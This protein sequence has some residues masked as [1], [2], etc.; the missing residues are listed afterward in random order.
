MRKE[1][2]WG[3]GIE[4]VKALY[5]LKEACIL[6]FIDSYKT[7]KVAKY[8]IKHPDDIPFDKGNYFYIATTDAAYCEI[9]Q[10]LLAKGYE[11]FVNFICWRCYKKKIC[12]LHGNCHMEPMKE[13]MINMPEFMNQYGFYPLTLVQNINGEIDETVLKHIDVLITQDIREDNSFGIKLSAKYLQSKIKKGGRIIVVPNLFGLGRAFYPQFEWNDKNGPIADDVNGLFPHGDRYIRQLADDGRSAD[14]IVGMLSSND[15]LPAEMIV[16]NFKYYFNE[17]RDREKG[18]DI[19]IYEYVLN[20]YKNKQLFWDQGHPT[21]F[22]I[23]EIVTQILAMLDI[24]GTLD[25]TWEMNGHE[26]FVYPCVKEQLGLD[27]GQDVI[28]ESGQKKGVS[29]MD[30]KEYVQ[31]LL[32]WNLTSTES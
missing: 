4:G 11:E 13:M 2:I 20:N 32:W 8:D 19:K 22:V 16:Q 9:K 31:E 26:E 10:L 23:K 17:I 21:N 28:R 5:N 27:W 30:F 7:G 1:Y 25:D 18:W 3:A 12:Y 24:T 15:F 6:A 14:E 29:R